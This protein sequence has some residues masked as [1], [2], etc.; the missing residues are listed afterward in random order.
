MSE[1]GQKL[2]DLALFAQLDG[3]ERD[4]L[5]Q[6]AASRRY[7]RGEMVFQEGD[8][9]DTF[10]AVLEGRVKIFKSSPDGKEQILHI[11]GPGEMFGEV[12]VFLGGVYPA[13]AEAL[14]SLEALVLPRARLVAHA[15]SNPDFAFKLL[16]SLS[17]RLHRFVSLVEDLSLKEVPARLSAYLLQ[18]NPV[19]RG[20]QPV[21]ALEISKAQLASL[22][23]TIPET[24]SRILTRMAKEG[25]LEA[26]GPR[27]LR[28]M[29]I[30]GLEELASGE[31]RLR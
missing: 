26:M 18:L 19:E 7:A 31:R 15:K 13:H 1:L 28:I 27:K 3:R 14:E 16:A 17:K 24:L 8:D 23:G 29:D 20:D 5:A 11:F 25:L 9:G 10:Y 21:V 6:L 12:A 30:D 22:L 2:G 4:E